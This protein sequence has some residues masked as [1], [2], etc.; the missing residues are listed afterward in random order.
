[1]LLKDLIFI[2]DSKAKTGSVDGVNIKNQVMLKGIFCPAAGVEFAI[3]AYDDTF[4]T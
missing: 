4:F 1:M 3:S 2:E